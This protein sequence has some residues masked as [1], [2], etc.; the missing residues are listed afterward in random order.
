LQ[1][2]SIGLAFL[3]LSLVVFSA[4]IVG[5]DGPDL[6]TDGDI[7]FA[8]PQKQDKHII[9][10]WHSTDH[11]QATDLPSEGR[12]IGMLEP[13]GIA[14]AELFFT[15][16]NDP[17]DWHKTPSLYQECVFDS[18]ESS[19]HCFSSLMRNSATNG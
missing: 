15:P 11:F 18:E 14:D 7:L 17:R 13:N 5:I 8:Q 19:G 12:T 9:A 1:V 6:C 4:F 16:W 10:G 2:G 3:S